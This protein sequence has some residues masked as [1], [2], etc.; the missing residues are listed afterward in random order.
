MEDVTDEGKIVKFD[1]CIKPISEIFLTLRLI[2]NQIL[3]SLK[4]NKIDSHFSYLPSMCNTKI[5]MDILR[6]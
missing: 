4:R 5:F 1:S 3:N 6:L 2:I